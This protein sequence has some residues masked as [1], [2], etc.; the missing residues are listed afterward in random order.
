MAGK[1]K[2]LEMID[3]SSTA[4]VLQVILWSMAVFAFVLG[5]NAGDRV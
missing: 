3:W 4:D 2:G 1:R 5:F